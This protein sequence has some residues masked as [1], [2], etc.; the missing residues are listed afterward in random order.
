M[1]TGRLRA[2]VALTCVLAL[3]AAACGN[4]DAALVDSGDGILT[5]GTLLPV[6]GDLAFR[7]PAKIAGARLAVADINEAGGVLGNQVLL[8]EGDSGDSTVDIANPTVDFLLQ[9][10]VDVILGAASS[11]VSKSVIDKIVGAQRIQFSPAN[12]SPD[13]TEYEDNGLYF[14]T[15]PSDVLQ[16]KVLADL[17]TQDGRTK[18][19]VIFRDEAY[20]SGL[21]EAFKSNFEANGG[22]VVKV[23][24]YAFDT[25]LFDPEVDTIQAAGP[26]AIVIIGFAESAS[27]IAA[28]NDR[29]IGPASAMAVYGVDA[30]VGGLGGEVED[31]SILSGFKGTA[32]SVDLTSISDFVERLDGFEDLAI[33]GVY[34]YGPESYDAV[35]ITALA[36]ELAESDDPELIAAQ[37]NGVTKD[38]T[39]CNDFASCREIIAADG[40]PDYDGVGGSYEFSGAGE[41]TVASFRIST[42]D[43][44]AV[45]NPE[46]DRY[47]LAAS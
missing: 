18:A 7:G 20:G 45:P 16:G 37:I 47:V 36:A 9:K 35:V 30:N 46:L 21:A 43:G 1:S 22:N 34:D 27:I 10:E 19:A 41:P 13:F 3:A 31:P 12:T 11:E 25:Q 38:G 8:L 24:P 33:E 23:V 44:G 42:Y 29:G 2:R 5:I 28:L 17:L 40:D 26:D 4:D 32:P 15:A 39:K 6:T 14:R